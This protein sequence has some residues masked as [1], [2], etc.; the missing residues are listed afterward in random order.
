[1][2]F[3]VET[4]PWN[5]WKLL[6]RETFDFELDARSSHTHS[7]PRIELKFDA[8]KASFGEKYRG[9]VQHVHDREGIMVFEQKS[10]VFIADTQNL[11]NLKIN[12]HCNKSP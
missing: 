11:P 1:M 7:T 12:D 6:Q 9:W 10:S 5:K 2:G 3:H 8:T 4:C